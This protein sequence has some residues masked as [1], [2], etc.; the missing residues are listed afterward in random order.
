MSRH[1][2][3][4][5]SS[6]RLERAYP[7]RQLSSLPDLLTDDQAYYEGAAALAFSINGA[8]EVLRCKHRRIGHAARELYTQQPLWWSPYP[9]RSWRS[10]LHSGAPDRLSRLLEWQI[11]GVE[12]WRKQ[13]R[14][15]IFAMVGPAQVIST[16]YT[17]VS[18]N[19]DYSCSTARLR[20]LDAAMDVISLSRRA[21]WCSTQPAPSD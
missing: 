2:L 5:I 19:N 13:A 7:L 21:C 18:H 3:E 14:Q 4:Y 11:I 15:G 1:S 16:A 12:R 8:C 6:P 20:R 17:Q 9:T 10:R